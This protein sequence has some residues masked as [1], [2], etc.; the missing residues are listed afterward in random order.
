V[1]DEKSKKSK[2][3]AGG[4]PQKVFVDDVSRDFR[5]VAAFAASS[6][7][8][9]RKPASRC[10]GRA[11]RLQQWQVRPDYLDLLQSASFWRTARDQAT[12]NAR[13]HGT[14]TP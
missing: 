2:K 5:H 6:S 11:S 7:E 12:H 8:K 1:L 14:F 3:S 4:C 10:E 13:S 9:S